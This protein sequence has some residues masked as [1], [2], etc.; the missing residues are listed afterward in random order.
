MKSKKELIIDELNQFDNRYFN[1]DQKDIIN[2]I[3]IKSDENNVQTW[4]DFLFSK[5]KL[6]FGFDY[7]PEVAKGRII[8]LINEEKLNINCGSLNE[9]KNENKL[10]IG[11]NFNALKALKLTHEEE[12]DIIYI[13]PPYNT[14]SAG[15]DGN[16]W[17]SK[18]V[19][20]GGGSKVL[21]QG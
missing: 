18:E 13:D 20:G 14:E 6:G 12:I 10:I 16:N 4:A 1:Q 3:L 21:L 15:N 5:R 9:T 7:S 8:T 11:D 17:S 2:D 19:I